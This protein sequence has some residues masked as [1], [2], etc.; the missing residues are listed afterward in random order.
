MDE[1]IVQEILHELFSSLEALETQSSAV[2]QFLKDQGMA[3]KD[4]LAPYLE[5]A[6]NASG[7]RWMAVRARI[8]HLVS[9]AI[10][11]AEEDAKKASKPAKESEGAATA[12]QEKQK[13]ESKSEQGED[14]IEE[15]AAKRDAKGDK[16]D[17]E[18]KQAVPRNNIARADEAEDDARED[19]RR[20]GDPSDQT[21]KNGEKA[22]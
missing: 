8:D 6:G 3:G 16:E 19:G 18:G 1:K 5:Q 2:L 4:E 13:P 20:E 15:T 17:Q 10:K 21:S 9:G 7:V 12:A 11:S 22:A 14:G